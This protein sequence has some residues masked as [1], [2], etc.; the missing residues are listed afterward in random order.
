M[1]AE[2]LREAQ[3]NT[4]LT[5]RVDLAEAGRMRLEL[6]GAGFPFPAH[7]EIRA[8]GDLLGHLLFWPGLASYR[9][10]PPGAL[11]TLFGEA[12]VDVTPVTPPVVRSQGEGR[13]AGLPTRKLELLSAI[14]GVKLE[15]PASQKRGKG[16]TV[17]CRTLV[18]FAGID[19]RTAVCHAGEVPLF[20]GYWWHDGGAGTFFEVATVQRHTD[21]PSTLL[22][23]PPPNAGFSA[24]GL[25]AVPN[26]IFL[27]RESLMA[28]RTGPAP[29]VAPSARDPSAP[30][31]GFVAANRTDRLMYLLVDGVPVVAVPASS[32]R[33]VIG[34]PRG[35]Y[36]IQ[37]R[38]F[39]GEQVGIARTVDIPSRIVVGSS[40]DAGAA[41]GG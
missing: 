10:I 39:L 13:R 41:D 32:E 18:D 23:V 19:P 20:A 17:L 4:A 33:Y 7:T 14:G 40:A 37:W 35:R 29:V 34:P 31:E 38:T 27:S 11:R 16:S 26:G 21:L 30:G 9:V 3:R 12:R 6:L 24:S 25:P 15:L 8:R 22:L 5:V 1:S 2:G 36:V 28:F